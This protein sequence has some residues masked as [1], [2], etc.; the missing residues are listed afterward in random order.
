MTKTKRPRPIKVHASGMESFRAWLG[1]HGLSSGTIDVYARD[2]QKALDAGGFVPRLT[3]DELAP[4]TRRH[5]LA[6]ARRWADF[7]D[8]KALLQ[9]LKKIRLPPPRRRTAKV[10]LERSQLFDLIDEIGRA[11]YLD[12]PMRGVIGM[13]ACRGFR[14]GDVLR[15][16]RAELE[17]ARETGT[18]SFE[19]KGRRRIEFKVLKTFRKSLNLL[20]DAGGKWGR[21]DELISP[22]AKPNGVRAAAARAVERAMV[23]VGVKLGIYGL[24]PHRLRRTYAVEYLRQMK[25]DPEALIHLTSHMRWA[26]M[27]TAMEY[28][29]HERG[30][31]LDTFAEKIFER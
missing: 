24:H 23:K 10:P 12:D 17:A 9:Q 29:D 27:S 5:I 21:V 6:A 4:K 16:R 22:N 11:K 19:A 7:D 31:E 14:C 13:M 1:T 2:V 25:G 15:L 3:D 28:V 18:L 30:D 26:S 8:D 20:T